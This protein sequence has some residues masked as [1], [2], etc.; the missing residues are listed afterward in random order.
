MPSRW[1]SFRIDAQSHWN[2]LTWDPVSTSVKTLG[3][4]N[5]TFQFLAEAR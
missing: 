4:V 5:A 3:P 2:A 1:A